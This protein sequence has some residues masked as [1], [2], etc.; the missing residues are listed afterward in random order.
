MASGVPAVA[1]GTVEPVTSVVPP[2]AGAAC[3]SRRLYVGGFGRAHEREQSRAAGGRSHQEHRAR[4]ASKRSRSRCARGA[5]ARGARGARRAGAQPSGGCRGNAP[6][7]RCGATGRAGRVQHHHGVTDSG[8]SSGFRRSACRIRG[9]DACARI[10]LWSLLG[11]LCDVVAGIRHEHG[12][13]QFGAGPALRPVGARAP[14]PLATAARTRAVRF[15][16]IA[17]CDDGRANAALN[18]AALGTRPGQ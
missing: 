3:A 5:T 7:A 13:C 14:I 12:G 11:R 18:D 16:V 8:R 17:A 6:A 4:E 10:W 1:A 9:C 2:C 15:S